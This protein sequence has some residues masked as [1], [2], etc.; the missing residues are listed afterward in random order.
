MP[1]LVPQAILALAL[2]L[3]VSCQG[4]SPQPAPDYGGRGALD[5]GSGD[6]RGTQGPTESTPTA[7]PP[8]DATPAPAPPS[9][10]EDEVFAL[11]SAAA[12]LDLFALRSR[13][14]PRMQLLPD[15]RIRRILH[16]P[17]N[18]GAQLRDLLV[19]RWLP[20]R[21]AA[22]NPGGSEVA[23]ELGADVTIT[24]ASNPLADTAA[25]NGP[26]FTTNQVWNKVPVADWLVVTGD[27]ETQAEVDQ[28]LSAWWSGRD[29]IEIRVV[30]IEREIS[31][32]D[33]FGSITEILPRSVDATFQGLVSEFPNSISGGGVFRFQDSDDFSTTLQWISRRGAASIRSVPSIV[34]RDHG[35]ARI[36]AITRTPYLQADRLDATGQA[37]TF[38]V[39]FADTG[40]KMNV[41]A[42]VVGLDRIFLE[43]EIAVT[44][45]NTA[46]TNPEIPA[47]ALSETS[48]PVPRVTIADGQTLWIGGL[49]SEFERELERKFPILGDIPLLGYLFKSMIHEKRKTEVLFTL[50]P[51]IIHYGGALPEV[52]QPSESAVQQ[53]FEKL[54]EG[55]LR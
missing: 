11:R 16:V 13:F 47:P 42:S 9:M 31:D 15:G 27:E 22:G 17:F 23:A 10:E 40:V 25:K 30:V 1:Q 8:A 53:A 38:K 2:A 43:L 55:G 50:T 7:A 46:L 5:L 49:H 44:S 48:L 33:D 24:T 4:A 21:F 14:G 3:L 51:T 18:S 45:L 39:A 41:A 32:A 6:L 20:E 28:W 37:S 36:S 26:K 19:T 29:H 12:P 34:L 52:E 35:S 54:D